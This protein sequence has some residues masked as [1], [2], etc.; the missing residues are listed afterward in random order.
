MSITAACAA[1]G[2]PRSSMYRLLESG[3]VAGNRV[4]NRWRVSAT[5]LEQWVN[6]T[7]VPETPAAADRRAFPEVEDR[8]Q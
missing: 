1:T 7:A 6:R 8:F 5:S 4:G 3:A 2:L